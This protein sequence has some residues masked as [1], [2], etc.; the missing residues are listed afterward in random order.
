VGRDALQR[1]CEARLAPGFRYRTVDC[2]GHWGRVDIL[3][4]KAVKDETVNADLTTFAILWNWCAR[5]TTGRGE[6]M[7]RLGLPDMPRLFTDDDAHRPSANPE[8]SER[9]IGFLDAHID[10]LR[11]QIQETVDMTKM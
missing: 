10:G 3:K 8:R 9:L 5:T 11:R 4:E 1:H 7:V 6:P 2:H